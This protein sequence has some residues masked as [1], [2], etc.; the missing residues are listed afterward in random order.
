MA[1]TKRGYKEIVSETRRFVKNAIATIQDTISPTGGRY[2]R[3][4]IQ[5]DLPNKIVEAVNDSG[6]ARACAGV[7]QRFIYGHGVPLEISKMMVNPSQT[8]DQLVDS[9]AAQ[10][11]YMEGFCFQVLY[12]NAGLVRYVH[13]VPVQHVRRRYDGGFLYDPS[14]GDE[15]FTLYNRGR[16]NAA[17]VPEFGTAVTADQRRQLAK[18]QIEKYGKQLGEFLFVYTPGVGPFYDQYPIPSYFS[19][20]DDIRADA[21]LSRLE[22]RNITNGFN[23]GLIIQTG[24]IN[25]SLVGEDGKTD[26]QRFHSDLDNFTGE[27]AAA[28]LHIAASTDGDR[29]MISRVDVDKLMDA[30]EN[31]TERLAKK[32]CRHMQTPPVL[33]GIETPGRLGSSQ[34]LVNMMKLF[35]LGI[36]KWR[37]QIEDAICKILPE[38]EGKVKIEPLR[39]FDHLPPEVMAVMTPAEIRDLY[40]LK[41]LENETPNN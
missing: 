21:A 30:T 33:I 1:A 9:A 15:Q 31:S 6:T 20:I 38:L 19:G 11:S 36:S 34:E 18:S 40:D 27:D 2:Y 3:Y 13:S 5:D 14:Y 29:A 26:L 35:D 17:R 24:P 23:T 25:N 28:I 8:L 16:M 32:I 41:P 22:L 10:T 4:G 37:Q 39:L 12:D 7:R